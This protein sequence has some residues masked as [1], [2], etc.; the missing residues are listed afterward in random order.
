MLSKQRKNLINEPTINNMVFQHNQTTKKYLKIINSFN[1]NHNYVDMNLLSNYDLIYGKYCTIITENGN[2]L[3]KKINDLNYIEIKLGGKRGGVMLI[4]KEDYENVSSHKWHQDNNGYVSGTIKGKKIR[5]HRYLMKPPVG[6]VVDHI[7]RNPLNNTRA[8]LRVVTANENAKNKGKP[9]KPTS[10]KYKGVYYDKN[11]DKYVMR[12]FIND[13]TKY[14]EYYKYELDA[15]IA[16]DMHIVHNNIEIINLNFPNNRDKYSRTKYIIPIKKEQTSKYIGVHKKD[17]IYIGRVS[18]NNKRIKVYY[19]NNEIECAKAC[20]NYIVTNEIPY[21]T[22][23]FPLDHPNYNPNSVIKTLCEQ[24]NNTT[25]KLLIKDATNDTLLDIEDYDKIKYYH[26]YVSNDGYVIVVQGRKKISLHRLLMNPPESLIVDHINTK[27][28]DNTKKNLRIL[29]KGKNSQNK[30]K[31]QNGTSIYIG[32]SF[33]KSRK[34]WAAEI[35]INEKKK[36]LRRSITEID[37]A[38]KRDLYILEHLKNEFYKLNFEWTNDEI[39]IWREKFY[40][41]ILTWNK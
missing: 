34:R 23:N 39:L 28:S 17:D 5:I 25:V 21:K 7:D 13:T 18:I 8:N 35:N 30:S 36:H 11:R 20:D 6:M 2:L 26:C 31:Q 12:I 9:N 24:V 29:P 38:R 33:D 4:D 10:S 14:T 40:E 41:E 15:A 19:G 1:P 37:A 16:Y 22:L 3:K 32:V 27:R